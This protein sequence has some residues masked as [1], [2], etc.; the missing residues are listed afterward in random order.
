MNLI[1]DLIA[2]LGLSEGVSLAVVALI[3]S[4]AGYL[5]AALYP[6]VIPFVT[7]LQAI[8]AVA[9]AGAAVGW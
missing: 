7:T 8:I 6:I 9:G 3:T 4:G 2:N 1:G 5:I